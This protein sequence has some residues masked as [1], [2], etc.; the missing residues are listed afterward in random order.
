MRKILVV[1]HAFH[2]KTRSSQFF[3]DLLARDFVL[4]LRNIDP[5]QPLDER[6]L[7]VPGGTELVL[8]W[9]M[10]YLAPVFLAQGF[11]TAVVPMYD[12][13]ANM[14]D[15]HWLWAR[16]AVFIN[17]S[18]RLHERVRL[19]GNRSLL[20]KYFK[21]PV[22]EGRRARFDG[23]LRVFLWQRRPAE[24]INLHMVET[25]FGDQL[26]AVHVHDAADDPALDTRAYLRPTRRSYRLSV[27]RWFEDPAEYERLLDEANAVVAPRPA[28]GIG[29]VLLEAMARGMLVVAA[30][31]PT[32][33]EYI[34]NQVNGVLF[35]PARI[36][37]GKFD[38]AEA[39]G[40]LAWRTAA[41]GHAR[42][43]DSAMDIIDFLNMAPR[44]AAVPGL[45]I[46]AFA[47]KLSR[48]YYGGGNAWQDYLLQNTD[49]IAAMSGLPL[50]GRVTAEGGYDPGLAMPAVPAARRARGE[51]HPEWL[52]RYTIPLNAAEVS[53]FVSEGEIA[54]RGGQAWI[55]GR[56]VTFGFR[57]DR[58]ANALTTL[59]IRCQKPKGAKEQVQFF[60]AL[61]GQPLGS[62]ELADKATELRFVLPPDV[63]RLDNSLRLLASRAM[64]EPDDD[65]ARSVGL[66]EIRFS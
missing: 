28:E 23:K 17:F 58:V 22:A 35:N 60:V 21:P 39:M 31:A 49:R 51:H 4:D 27:S 20:V 34:A 59:S 16:G 63:L 6:A 33:D 32:H 13:S 37:W 42:W 24:G 62:A 44:P 7:A 61:N 56:A 38:R 55:V 48:A 52:R 40:A 47:T 19:L 41:E 26:G 11:P 10:D 5:E 66:S 46:G 30:D 9:Q 1:D 64:A 50:V 43:R 14:P 29:M 18:R 8:L 36:G 53:L 57:T 45:D 2:Q 65:R 3:L 12:G 54:Q 25:L 15:L